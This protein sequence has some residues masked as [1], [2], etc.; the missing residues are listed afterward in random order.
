MSLALAGLDGGLRVRL[1]EGDW[2]ACVAA[3]GGSLDGPLRPAVESSSTDVD[4]ALVQAVAIAVGGPSFVQLT[5]A[6]RD[7][8]LVAR[9]GCLGRS[10]VGAARVVL[11][12]GVAGDDPVA[13][14]GV[15]VSAFPPDRL[16]PRSCAWSLPTGPAPDPAPVTLSCCRTQWR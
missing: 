8:G 2:A 6:A 11:P 15:E 10:A 9:I 5:T 1:D 14:P 3:G 13:V 7:R 12:A 4:P 16:V